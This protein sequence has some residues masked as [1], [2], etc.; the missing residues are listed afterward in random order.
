LRCRVGAPPT[1]AKAT[2][3]LLAPGC[4]ARRRRVAANARRDLRWR[5]PSS[6]TRCWRAKSPRGPLRGVREARRVPQR[7]AV[8]AAWGRGLG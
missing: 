5:R 1:Q 6:S 7:S 3:R 2:L 8:W 4:S